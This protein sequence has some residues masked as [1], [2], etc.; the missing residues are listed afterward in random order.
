MVYRK[1]NKH[2]NADGG[3]Y[4]FLIAKYAPSQSF[5][6]MIGF[7]Q[8]GKIQRV[9]ENIK[10]SIRQLKLRNCENEK[11]GQLLESD[12]LLQTIGNNENTFYSSHSRWD[13]SINKMLSPIQ[14]YHIFFDFTK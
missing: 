8:K 3:V 14:I 2:K 12:L 11:F 4:R 10:D 6:G 9:L 5:G 13:K 7:V 1:E